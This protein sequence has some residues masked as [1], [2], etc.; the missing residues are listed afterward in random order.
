M[1]TKTLPLTDLLLDI[2]RTEYGVPDST[3]ADTGFDTLDFDSLVLLELAVD[4]SRRFD[5]EVADDELQ[6]A[7]T[8]AA[9][10]DLL[11]SKGVQV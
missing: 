6:A 9:M 1:T 5:V 11:T 7:G 8:V 2:L 3:D 10:A 4:L